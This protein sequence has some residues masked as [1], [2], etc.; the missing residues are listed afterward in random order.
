MTSL[1]T[2]H[3]HIPAPDG[4]RQDRFDELR[5]GF[6][7]VETTEGVVHVRGT[8]PMGAVEYKAVGGGAAYLVYSHGGDPTRGFCAAYWPGKGQMASFALPETAAKVAQ[9]INDWLRVEQNE[10]A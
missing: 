8:G 5:A 4:I 7:R 10:L 9:E 2:P 3:I 1:P 6:R